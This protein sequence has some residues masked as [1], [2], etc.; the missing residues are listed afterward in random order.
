[1]DAASSVTKF[2]PQRAAQELL[3]RR[4]I[5]LKLTDWARYKGFDPAKHHQLIISEIEL[6][7]K[8]RMTCSCSLHRRVG[9]EHYVSIL[10]P[11][12]Y[13]ANHQ[14]THLGGHSLG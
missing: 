9:Q 1:M 10:L 7:S 3:K 12:W 2:S 11:S 6:S 14:P 5:R 4:S 13:L 8:A